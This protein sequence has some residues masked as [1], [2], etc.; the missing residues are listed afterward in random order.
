MVP[1]D[2]LGGPFPVTLQCCHSHLGAVAPPSH[3]LPLFLITGGLCR[4]WLAHTGPPSSDIAKRCLRWPQT[5]SS[6]V[7]SRRWT[8]T[9][10]GLSRDCNQELRA[11]LGKEVLDHSPGSGFL[12]P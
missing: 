7:L 8:F 5:L 9:Y 11:G 4:Y 10:L 6:V 2:S 1:G 12:R 3:I